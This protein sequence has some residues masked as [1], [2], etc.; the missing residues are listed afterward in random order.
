MKDHYDFT[1][2][3]RGAVIPPP[4]NKVQISIRLDPD[5]LDWFR[6]Q[7]KGGGSYQALINQALRDHIEGKDL[8]N[9]FDAAL[10]AQK[11]QELDELRSLLQKFSKSLLDAALRAQ[12][13]QELDELRSVLREELAS[14]KTG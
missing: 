5:I 1:H 6:N 7:V 12:R 8:R 2:G 4:P 11:D 10:R 9:F 3:K 13:N 14:L